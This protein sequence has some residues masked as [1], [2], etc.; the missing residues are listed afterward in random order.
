MVLGCVRHRDTRTIEDEHR[1]TVPFPLVTR[2]RVQLCRSPGCQARN[3]TPCSLRTSRILASVKMS[4]KGSPSLRAK[5]AR[6]ASKL[7]M[8]PP[9]GRRRFQPP[10]DWGLH[11]LW[12]KGDQRE[13][14]F[15]GRESR[16]VQQ[17]TTASIE[18]NAHGT[19][20]QAAEPG[21][22]SM[23]SLEAAA[24]PE[25]AAMISVTS[26]HPLYACIGVTCSAS[27][28]LRLS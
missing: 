28:E 7:D 9:A 23:P 27:R 3:G 2:D 4:A 12:N 10:D 17:S 13:P 16:N 6:T 20:S 11:C 8:E 21:S 18:R 1:A 14:D 19:Y 22:T 15:P 26:R 5:R 25:C 24:S